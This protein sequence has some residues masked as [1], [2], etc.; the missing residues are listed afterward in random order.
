MLLISII[1]LLPPANPE[2]SN[3]N[4]LQIFEAPLMVGFFTCILGILPATIIGSVGGAL[5]GSIFGLWRK[6]LP[7]PLAALISGIIG[8]TIV[9]VVNYLLWS[10]LQANGLHD[11]LGNP[12]NFSRFLFIPLE[13]PSI[14]MLFSLINPYLVPSI[15]AI[16]V[17]IYIEWK[18]N[19]GETSNF[20]NQQSN[21]S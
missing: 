2:F 21:I 8:I 13:N 9:L 6:K 5:I 17:S 19:N 18:I 16:L 3:P 4:T 11:K 7:N 1:L 20:S 15:I 10:N 14:V 12:I